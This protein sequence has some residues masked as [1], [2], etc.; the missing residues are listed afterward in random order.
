MI[1][2]FERTG[3]EDRKLI[4]KSSILHNTAVVVLENIFIFNNVAL[5]GKSA[6]WLRDSIQAILLLYMKCEVFGEL[7]NLAYE[8]FAGFG[9]F[10]L[11]EELVIFQQFVS[12]AICF[13]FI[14]VKDVLYK[15]PSMQID[16]E[17]RLKASEAV[18]KV[19]ICMI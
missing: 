3:P 7:A 5:I 10:R 14:T 17:R 11:V 8:E 6:F 15:H 16:F 19:R 2:H 18:L 12:Y 4:E 9:A 13:V 1:V